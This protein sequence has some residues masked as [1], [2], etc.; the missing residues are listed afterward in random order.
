MKLKKMQL[1]VLL[2]LTFAGTA[3]TMPPRDAQGAQTFTGEITDTICARYKGHAHM[4]EE[5]KTMGNDKKTC[6]KKCIEQLGA[7]YVFYDDGKQTTYEI[8]DQ[9][10]I[11]AFAGHKVRVSGTLQKNKKIEVSD[12]HRAD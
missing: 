10:K 12:V 4:M 9:D 6:I 1:P 11:A 5:L 7:H 8:T 3:W 2:L